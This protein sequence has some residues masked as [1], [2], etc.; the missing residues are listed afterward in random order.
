MMEVFDIIKDILA[1]VAP[2]LSP[3][4]D[5]RIEMTVSGGRVLFNWLLSLFTS[6]NRPVAKVR[7]SNSFRNSFANL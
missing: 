2:S 5:Y 7:L 3:G 4:N 6:F 1:I